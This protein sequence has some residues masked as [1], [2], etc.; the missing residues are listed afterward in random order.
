MVLVLLREILLQR[1]SFFS[2]TP[3]I[4]YVFIDMEFIMLPSRTYCISFKIFGYIKRHAAFW[5]YAHEEFFIVE[6]MYG[7]S[8]GLIFQVLPHLPYFVFLSDIILIR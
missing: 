1:G 2:N 7:L 3:L 6:Y 4:Q 5:D 8:L